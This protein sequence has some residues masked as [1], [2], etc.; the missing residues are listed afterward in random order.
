MRQF[1]GVLAVPR[2]GQ[3]TCLP[4]WNDT[5]RANAGNCICCFFQE[6]WRRFDASREKGA[7]I[8]L[9]DDAPRWEWALPR[10]AAGRHRSVF[11]HETRRPGLPRHAPRRQSAYSRL[12]PQLLCRAYALE[13]DGARAGANP[14]RPR[15]PRARPLPLPRPSVFTAAFPPGARARAWREV[16][17]TAFLRDVAHDPGRV[18]ARPHGR[19]DT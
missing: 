8:P 7:P 1:V 12:Q 19:R 14:P 5:N 11:C 15:L 13:A 2:P 17:T 6:K 3:T 4:C 9:S 16:A 10:A 18:S